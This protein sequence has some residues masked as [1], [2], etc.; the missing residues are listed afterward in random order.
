M[1]FGEEVERTLWRRFVGFSRVERPWNG[2][3]DAG[4]LGGARM[5]ALYMRRERGRGK[6]ECDDQRMQNGEEILLPMYARRSCQGGR[7]CVARCIAPPSHGGESSC[8]PFL[9]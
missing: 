3:A 2:R 9:L 1:R 6:Q 5:V 7:V 8:L 4:E